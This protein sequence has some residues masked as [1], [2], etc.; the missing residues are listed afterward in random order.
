MGGAP[1]SG[2]FVVVT[3]RLRVLQT[4]VHTV[5]FSFYPL[6]PTDVTYQGETVLGDVR[7]ARVSASVGRGL[8][9]PVIMKP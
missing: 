3:L 8:Y 9:L 6:R 4:G 5:R 2:S 1:A 7:G